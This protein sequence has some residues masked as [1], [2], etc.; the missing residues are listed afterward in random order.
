MVTLTEDSRCPKLLRQ[1]LRNKKILPEKIWDIVIDYIRSFDV[2]TLEVS[3]ELKDDMMYPINCIEEEWDA[4]NV[5]CAKLRFGELQK[6]LNIDNFSDFYFWRPGDF[7]EDDWKF[8][9]RHSN[10]LY[11]HFDAGCAYSGFDVAGWGRV[12]Y[13]KDVQKLWDYGMTSSDR[14][15]ILRAVG[16]LEVG[17]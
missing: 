2:P 10:G 13:A 4:D 9:V 6:M 15:E 12:A 1:Q 8:L 11:I 14:D 5:D 16:A 7:D 3:E 17:E